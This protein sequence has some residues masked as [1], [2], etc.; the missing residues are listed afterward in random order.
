GIR[1]DLRASR[2]ERLI[3]LSVSD[4]RVNVSTKLG[5]EVE[6]GNKEVGLPFWS[7]GVGRFWLN[8]KNQIGSQS[9]VKLGLVFPLAIGKDDFLTF[10]ARRMSGT[11]GGSIDAYFAG[12]D[13]FS[14]FNLP[15][16]FKFSLMPAGQSSNSSIINSGDVTTLPNLKAGEPPVIV[17][18][19]RTF[20][21]EGLILQL[22]IPTIIQLNLNNFVQVSVGFGI[23]NVYKSI[24]PGSAVGGYTDSRG[25]NYIYTAEQADKIQDIER[26]SDVISPH[27]E[28]DYV[29]HQGSK[30]GLNIAYDHLFTFGGWIELI[31]DR[32]RIEMSY[33]APII[34]DAKPWEPS[35]FFYI[36][37]RFYF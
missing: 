6:L 36:T 21:R 19:G 1:S 15:I 5:L 11:F 35:S 17:P 37:P 9:S 32:F 3:D 14:G 4:L 31:E 33:T 13:F 29:N 30:F 23:Q 22:F 2:Y 10:K 27:F 8:L 18:A 25:K 20:Y 12:I 7:S 24:L 28:V 16:A 34:R 26:V